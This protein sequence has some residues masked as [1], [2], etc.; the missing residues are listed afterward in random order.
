MMP[1]S[2]GLSCQVFVRFNVDGFEPPTS[3]IESRHKTQNQLNDICCN[4]QGGIG[5]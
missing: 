1:N 3:E 2:D 5:V 4:H